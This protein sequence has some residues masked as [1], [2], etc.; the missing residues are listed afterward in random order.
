MRLRRRCVLFKAERSGGQTRTDALVGVARS[1]AGRQRAETLA[2]CHW[3]AGLR[4]DL[5][6]LAAL[7]ANQ[8][9]NGYRAPERG[10]GQRSSDRQN[11]PQSVQRRS[12]ARARE[13]YLGRSRG[14]A[15]L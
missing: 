12:Y 7:S 1:I 4:S 6:E 13:Q 15:A 9:R 10:R 2:V 14:T 5:S 8:R 11:V 3:A